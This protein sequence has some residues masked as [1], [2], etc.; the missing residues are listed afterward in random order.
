[1][2]APASMA[3]V[4]VLVAALVVLSSWSPVQVAVGQVT[5]A[6]AGQIN[7]CNNNCTNACNAVGDAACP[8]S[9]F[10]NPPANPQVCTACK[11]TASNECYPQCAN[12]CYLN[13]DPSITS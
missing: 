10:G 7:S 3:S 4:V 5:T 13:P 12:G 11:T 2:A 1:M 8:G 6:N 9:C